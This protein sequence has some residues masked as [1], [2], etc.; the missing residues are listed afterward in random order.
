MDDQSKLFLVDFKEEDTD[1]WTASN[2]GK[3][4]C[5]A[6]WERLRAQGNEEKWQRLIWFNQN[7]P[8]IHL[9]GGYWLAI[10][11]NTKDRMICWGT[12]DDSARVFL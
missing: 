9:L 2:S 10:R 5:A 3:Y 6:T 11:N 4:V 8:D 7:I 12:I 1:V